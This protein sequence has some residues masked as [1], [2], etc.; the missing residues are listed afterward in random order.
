MIG[1]IEEVMKE[2]NEE[3][4]KKERIDVEFNIMDRKVKEL[5]IDERISESKYHNKGN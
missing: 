2:Y 1:D 4:G 5:E 3:G